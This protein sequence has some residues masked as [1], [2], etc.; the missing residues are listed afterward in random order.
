MIV[1]NKKQ[2]FKI[3]KMGE[4]EEGIQLL[5]NIIARFY[6]YNRATE[7]KIGNDENV[8]HRPYGLRADSGKFYPHRTFAKFRGA[9]Y[10]T[11]TTIVTISMQTI[12]N[13]FF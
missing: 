2:I 13:L 11:A 10:E 1:L 5:A 12:K 6:G 7:I 8:I 9:H 3:M 4:I